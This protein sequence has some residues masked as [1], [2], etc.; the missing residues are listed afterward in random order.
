MSEV[1]PEIKT[2]KERTPGEIFNNFVISKL[3][4][5]VFKY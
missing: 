4:I 3:M 2:K 5:H 1:T